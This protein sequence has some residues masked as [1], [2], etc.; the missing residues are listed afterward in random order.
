[1]ADLP[2]GPTVRNCGELVS[3]R[4]SSASKAKA[5]AG[6]I[7]E[8]AGGISFVPILWEPQSDLFTD[9]RLALQ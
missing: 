6:G 1:M 2:G 9:G 4:R 7:G 5:I 8:C 3:T